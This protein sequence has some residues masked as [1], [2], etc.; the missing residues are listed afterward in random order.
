MAHNC[1]AVNPDFRW[2]ERPGAFPLLQ[3]RM[4][5]SQ[6]NW[7]DGWGWWSRVQTFLYYFLKVSVWL[8]WIM[9]TGTSCTAEDN[10]YPL[11]SSGRGTLEE[12]DALY[13]I[14]YRKRMQ[15]NF[16][17]I[18]SIVR[19]KM[20]RYFER[21]FVHE[22]SLILERKCAWTLTS[23]QGAYRSFSS[24][25]VFNTNWKRSCNT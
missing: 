12:R 2:I 13:I 10:A 7:T 9:R 16:V 14:L 15:T 3:D 25:H 17:Q 5:W 6:R 8:L 11:G 23:T 19:L 1:A 4:L 22:N 21:N 24:T 20:C 18:F